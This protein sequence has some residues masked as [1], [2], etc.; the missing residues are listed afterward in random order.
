MEGSNNYDKTTRD[1]TITTPEV[2]HHKTNNLITFGQ[3]GIGITAIVIVILLA[4]YI[5][6]VKYERRISKYSLKSTDN[7]NNTSLLD[8]LYIQYQNFINKFSNSIKKS[9]V[10]SKYSKRY[11]KYSDAFLLDDSDGTKFMARKFVIG[12]IFILVAIIFK[13]FRFDLLR[14]YQMIIPFFFG[15]YT[16]NLIYINKYYMYRKQIENDLVEAIVVM[17]NAFKAGMTI[18]QAVNL[19]VKQLDGPISREFEKIA[20]ELSFGIDVEVAFTRFSDRIKVAEAVYL[21]SSLAVLSKTGGNIVKVFDSI[22]KTLM[23]KR[24][25]ENELKSL[26]S[27][28]RFIMYVLICVPVAFALLIGLINKDYFKPLIENPLGFVIIGISLIIY[29]TYIYVV[30]KVMKVRI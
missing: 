11:I 1:V 20:M 29:I 27:S 25:L 3:I 10:L 4:R 23:N 7:K 26:T 18:T 19:V 22:E 8:S 2:V 6:G 13:L 28:S 15:F 9:Q 14:G 17:N 5:Q 16:L 21:T 30:R 12:F 24:K